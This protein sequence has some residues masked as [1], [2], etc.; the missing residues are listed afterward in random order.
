MGLKGGRCLVD[1]QQQHKLRSSMCAE[2]HRTQEESED[3]LIWGSA[4]GQRGV[5]A[6]CEATRQVLCHAVPQ[7][8][9]GCNVLQRCDAT[10]VPCSAVM[11]LQCLAALSGG[12][13]NGLTQSVLPALS[14]CELFI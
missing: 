6:S 12:T 5:G 7:T 4:P 2:S 9:P 11:Q 14:V 13:L 3:A 1:P 10:S 8:A